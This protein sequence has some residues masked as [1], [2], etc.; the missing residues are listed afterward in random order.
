M[1]FKKEPA[2]LEFSAVNL[3][4]TAHGSGPTKQDLI[5]AMIPPACRYKHQG[6]R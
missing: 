1:Q 4:G 5:T 2:I 3:T 6:L